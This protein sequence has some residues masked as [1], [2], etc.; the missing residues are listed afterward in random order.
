VLTRGI[1]DH[2]TLVIVGLVWHIRFSE[3][4]IPCVWNGVAVLHSSHAI[5][6]IYVSSFHLV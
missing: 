5:M 4:C 6:Y 3:F 1:F 2:F